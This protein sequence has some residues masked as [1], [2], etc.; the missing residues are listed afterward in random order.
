VSVTG[1]LGVAGMGGRSSA[2]L[3]RPGIRAIP[4][5]AARRSGAEAVMVI[6]YIYQSGRRTGCAVATNFYL[7][8]LLM[9]AVSADSRAKWTIESS[10]AHKFRYR[11][12]LSFPDP[13][14]K[15]WIAD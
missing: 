4:S 5:R 13:R 3:D 8:I 11:S 14:Q 10:R 12:E 2:G 6:L 9:F 15:C 7:L 1:F